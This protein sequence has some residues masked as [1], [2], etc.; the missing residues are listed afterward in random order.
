VLEADRAGQ[1]AAGAHH[2]VLDLE[3]AVSEPARYPVAVG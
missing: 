2:R 1:L 3:L